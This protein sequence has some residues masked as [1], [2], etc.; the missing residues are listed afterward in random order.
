MELAYRTA[1]LRLA[2]PFTI[3]RSTSLEEEVIWV[4]LAQDGVS[5]FGE[6]QPQEHYGESLEGATAFLDEARGVLGDDPF[7]LEAIEARLG[8][9]PGNPAAKAAL[10][11]AL[12]DLCGKL[13]GQP[14]WR[15]LGLSP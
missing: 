4:E 5:G 3:S 7:A 6:A 9:L 1:T 2:E 15:L 14:V 12:H 11:A 8:G 10:D 13:L